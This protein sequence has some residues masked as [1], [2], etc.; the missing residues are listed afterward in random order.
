MGP[1]FCTSVYL[2][3]M[4]RLNTFENSFYNTYSSIRCST[5]DF[6]NSL[7]QEERGLVTIVPEMPLK[8]QKLVA[9]GYSGV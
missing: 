7:L 2:Q 4:Q 6:I 5:Y 3:F 1:F 8:F 9:A